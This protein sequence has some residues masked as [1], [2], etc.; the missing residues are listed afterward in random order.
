MWDRYQY[1]EIALEKVLVMGNASFVIFPSNK[2]IVYVV[3]PSVLGLNSKK[4]TF[5]IKTMM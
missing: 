4:L 1:W 5:Y 3:D 2:T